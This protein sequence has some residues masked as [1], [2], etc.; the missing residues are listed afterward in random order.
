MAS[1]SETGGETGGSGLGE[2]GGS[3]AP[4]PDPELVECEKMNT[5]RWTELW[6]AK[7]LRGRD[8]HVSVTAGGEG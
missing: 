7:T 8:S 3:V 4:P 1:T 2:Q 6:E 5:L